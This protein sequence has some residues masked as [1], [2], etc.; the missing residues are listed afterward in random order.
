MANQEKAQ[1]RN[2]SDKEQWFIESQHHCA[3][4]NTEL[5]IRI[6]REPDAPFL[7]EEASC[8]K[9]KIKTRV[10]SHGIQ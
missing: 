8:P 4:C 9:C 2:K 3:L 7:I 1:S 5:R 6:R 10:K